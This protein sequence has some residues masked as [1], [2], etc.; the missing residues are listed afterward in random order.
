MNLWP[1][2]HSPLP[3]ARS[4]S[5]AGFLPNITGA[6]RL[7]RVRKRTFLD[8]TTFHHSLS[9]R[10]CLFLKIFS[11]PL[12][13]GKKTITPLFDLQVLKQSEFV[14]GRLLKKH[15]PFKA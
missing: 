12:F 1:I 15:S 10:F 4:L 9:S 13:T 14:I 11:S 3:Y 6:A 8:F 5:V 7:P 2:A